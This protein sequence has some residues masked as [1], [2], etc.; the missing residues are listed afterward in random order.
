MHD[1]CVESCEIIANAL[2]SREPVPELPEIG[3]QVH[4][5]ESKLDEFRRSATG[6]QEVQTSVLRVL[7]VTTHMHLLVGELNDCRDKANALDWKAWQQ[8]WL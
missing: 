4:H 1:S 2:T 7:S 8:N 5:L 3:G 6:D